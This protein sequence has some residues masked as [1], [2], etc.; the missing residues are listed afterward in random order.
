MKS[1][2]IIIQI[3]NSSRKH[4]NLN[5]ILIIQFSIDKNAAEVSDLDKF[6]MESACFDIRSDLIRKK[7]KTERFWE[8]SWNRE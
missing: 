2:S 3:F 6:A 5:S 4:R 8:D 7:N 1:E